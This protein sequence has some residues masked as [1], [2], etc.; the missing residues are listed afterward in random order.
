M[1]EV[2]E[3]LGWM[4]GEMVSGDDAEEEREDGGETLLV[5]EGERASLTSLVS[6][7]MMTVISL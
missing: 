4:M 1:L 2:G 5:G 3:S 7:S 6:T